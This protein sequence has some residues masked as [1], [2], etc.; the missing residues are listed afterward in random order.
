M[1]ALTCVSMHSR[2]PELEL[3]HAVRV[4]GHAGDSGSSRR[5]RALAR[6]DSAS[7]TS[8]RWASFVIF[9]ISPIGRWL[10]KLVS[11]SF[12]GVQK[13]ARAG[14]E[15]LSTEAGAGRG[16]SGFFT[17]DSSF[18]SWQSCLDGDKHE[19]RARSGIAERVEQR[20]KNQTRTCGSSSR[21]PVRVKIGQQ[22][23]ARVQR[24]PHKAGP[25]LSRP[26]GREQSL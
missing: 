10:Q 8:E 23:C 22:T 15:D 14:N 25:C 20:A 11:A 6:D 9:E 3:G 21:P 19:I 26:T 12:E 7:A 16:R 18:G 17:L 24:V 13:A 2:R 5:G 4:I 1:P